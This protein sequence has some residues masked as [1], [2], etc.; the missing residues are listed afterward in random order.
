MRNKLLAV[1]AA[2]AVMFGLATLTAT[3]A[4]ANV[5]GVHAINADTYPY[6]RNL[7]VI[8]NRHDG[9]PYAAGGYD[10]L[11]RYGYDA[12]AWLGW[13]TFA[14]W[15]SG[16]GY[17]FCLWKDPVGGGAST[18]ILD[19][20]PAAGAVIWMSNTLN[21]GSNYRMFALINGVEFSG[22]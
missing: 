13:N 6:N 12:H 9:T 3:P 17:R 16:G 19:V 10:A 20:V 11:L 8:E 7:G 21:D 15:Y 18:K 1:L 22:C 4:S 5:A 14:G 2:V